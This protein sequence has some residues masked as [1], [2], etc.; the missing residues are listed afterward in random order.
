MN[1][2]RVYNRDEGVDTILDD[3]LAAVLNILIYC[4]IV[5]AH[6]NTQHIVL[7]HLTCLLVTVN[8][9]LASK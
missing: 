1:A 6:V 9:C 5:P 7:S 2:H 8:G 3:L 4:V